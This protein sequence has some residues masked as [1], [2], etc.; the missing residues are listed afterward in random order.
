M[1][2]FE[3]TSIHWHGIHMKGSQYMDG[4][5]MLTQC[6]IN[7]NSLFTYRYVNNNRGNTPPRIES[8]HTL[9]NF[10]VGFLKIIFV[11]VFTCSFIFSYFYF[12]N[13]VN[14]FS[15]FS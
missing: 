4:V 10:E 6:P 8:S 3:T 12:K 1:E 13:H 2:T 9:D 7:P 5:A 15:G 11:R 14:R